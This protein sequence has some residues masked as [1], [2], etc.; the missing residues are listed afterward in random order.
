MYQPRSSVEK[1]A[2]YFVIFLM[3]FGLVAIIFDFDNPH[4]FVSIVVP[5]MSLQF[6]YTNRSSQSTIEFSDRETFITNLKTILLRHYNIAD[7]TDDTIL[8]RPTGIRGL[9]GEPIFVQIEEFQAR[10]TSSPREIDNIKKKIY[11]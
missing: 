2:Q 11:Q 3:W 4:I 10:I 9:L 7:Q 1:F 8:F 6:T 5:I